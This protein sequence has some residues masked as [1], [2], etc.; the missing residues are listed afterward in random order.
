[1]KYK[2]YRSDAKKRRDDDL[3]ALYKHIVSERDS[4]SFS[5]VASEIYRS[6]APRFYVGVQRASI[7]VRAILK[8]GCISSMYPE[9]QMMYRE[10]FARFLRERESFPE[11][12]IEELCA[13]VIH[14]TAPSFYMTLKSIMQ[15]ITVIRKARRNATRK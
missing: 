8:G 14:R 7:V 10:I 4:I 11:L 1:M 5:D 12:S 3:Y 6:S 13:R 2:G 15:T 9:R